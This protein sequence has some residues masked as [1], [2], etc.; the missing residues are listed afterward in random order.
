M[1][2]TPGFL[3]IDEPSTIDKRA[4]T[5]VVTRAA[6]VV[7][8]EVVSI[9]SAD[10]AT[11]ESITK[12]D[13][14]GSMRTVSTDAAGT[15]QQAITA[16]GDAK[17]TLDGEAVTIS[18]T[19][20]VSGPLTDAELRAT[21]VPVSG[22]VTIGTFPDNEP[23]N[24]AQVGG[25]ATVTGGVA[26]SVGVGGLAA[27]DAATAG[28]PV[29][30]GAQMETMADSA[31]GTRAGTD[32]DAVKLA[33]TDG[34]LFAIPTGPQ[35]WSYHENGSSTVTDATVHAAPGAGLSIY[36]TSIIFSTGAAT[37]WNILFEEAGTTTVLGPFYL[38]AVAGRG[39]CIY[40]ATPKKITA[41]TSLT[42]TTSVA[43]LHSIDVTGFIAPG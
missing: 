32:G 9:G 28:N 27:H 20:P 42:V 21:P 16:A 8:R 11:P 38:E 24:L 23:F 26:G 19:V 22:T 10:D 18:G 34:A 43:I 1:A 33:S 7:H 14:T 4:D 29:L 35:T 31:P 15:N 6:T 30:N 41:N 2:V 37:A 25:T 5:N 36:V 39:A 3:G 40:F 13:A 12:V 17:V